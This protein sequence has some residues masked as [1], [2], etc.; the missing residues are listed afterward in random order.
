MNI[1]EETY[2]ISLLRY[3]GP[4]SGLLVRLVNCVGNI[5][6]ALRVCACVIVLLLHLG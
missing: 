4:L 1:V 3:I 5:P 6:L 2:A